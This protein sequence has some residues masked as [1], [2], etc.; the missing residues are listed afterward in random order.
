MS[1]TRLV[2]FD[3]CQLYYKVKKKDAVYKLFDVE[4]LINEISKKKLERKVIEVYEGCKVRIEK[5]DFDEKN[6]LWTLRLL[7]LRED[8]LGFIVK[9]DEEA[10]PIELGDDEYLGEDMTMLFDVN[11][12]VSMIQRNRYALGFKN[13][14]KLMQ[15]IL[16]IENLL[17]D[18]CPITKVVDA[19]A[20][21]RDYFKSIEIRFAN[22]KGK[23]ID[24][25]GG[26]L[27]TIM[28]AYKSLNGGGGAFIVNLGRTKKASLDKEQTREL[29]NEIQQNKD[30]LNAAIL[31]AK[32]AEDND[33]D[34]INLFD[35]VYSVF[36]PYELAERTSLEYSYCIKKMTEKYLIDKDKI[37]A[38]L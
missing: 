34:I 9:P 37:I 19:K 22:I 23:D 38:L 25:I 36:V 18:I 33:V 14:Q 26:A 8:N 20:I 28:K 15:K 2:K 12:N 24:S 1:F 32:D 27:G 10:K 11:N 16:N 4:V 21:Q 6:T 7:R 31:R 17:I 3:Y 29:L 35:N 30:V 5:F 13:L